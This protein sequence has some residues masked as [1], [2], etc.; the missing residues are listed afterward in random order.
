MGFVQLLQ[1]PACSPVSVNSQQVEGEE[2]AQISKACNL[3]GSGGGVGTAIASLPC[4]HQASRAWSGLARHKAPSC[5]HWPA[6][7]QRLGTSSTSCSLPLSVLVPQLPGRLCLYITSPRLHC[8]TS[9]AL[10]WAPEHQCCCNM[11]WPSWGS[12]WVV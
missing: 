2:E 10:A 8:S 4:C 1:A 3:R 6:S 12:M 7:T 11:H 9:G 5:L